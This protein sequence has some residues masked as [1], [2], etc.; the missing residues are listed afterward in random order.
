MKEEAELKG[1]KKRQNQMMRE[2]VK[3]KVKKEKKR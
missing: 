1:N 3:E 2:E